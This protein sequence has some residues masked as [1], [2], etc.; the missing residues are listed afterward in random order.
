M[1]WNE[2]R[3]T[4][5]RVMWDDGATASQIADALGGVSRNAVIGKAHR[6]GLKMRSIDDLQ[7]QAEKMSNL[8]VTQVRAALNRLFDGRVSVADLKSTDKE[9]A[10]KRTTRELA[11]LAVMMTNFES[12]NIK[13]RPDSP[14]ELLMGD[15][16]KVRSRPWTGNF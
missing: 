9:L 4:I 3:I 1:S 15:H 16:C 11:A 10:N 2:E 7:G 12:D 13:F 6:L 14:R 5:L 8:R